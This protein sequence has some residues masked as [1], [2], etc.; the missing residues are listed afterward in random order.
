MKKNDLLDTELSETPSVP[1]RGVRSIAVP[2]VAAALV[3]ASA[4]C[5]VEV[6]GRA[7]S[8]GGVY[9]ADVPNTDDAGI[10]DAGPRV[11]D[12]GLYAPDTGD[13]EGP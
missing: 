8:D 6:I 12:A 1:V 3:T 13:D 9:P 5:S 4:G 10:A 2:L 7:V 11:N